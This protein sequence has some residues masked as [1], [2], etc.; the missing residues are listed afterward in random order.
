MSTQTSPPKNSDGRPRRAGDLPAPRYRRLFGIQK[1]T[2]IQ[3]GIFVV[4]VVLVLAPLVPTIYQ[5]LLNKPLYAAGGIFTPSNYVHLFTEGGFGKVVLNSLYFAALTTVIAVAISIILAVLVIRTK[6]PAGRAMGGLLLWPIYISPL[7]MAFGFILMYG[8]SGFISTAARAVI[9][10]VPWNL[11]SIPG[12]AF[13]QAVT[14]VPI[15]YLYCSGALKL[16]D[17][18]L[19]AAARTCGAKPLRILW[20]VVIP[21]VRPAIL[22]SALLIFS[23]SIEELSIPLLLGRPS[24]INMFSSFIYINGLAKS[25]PDYGLVGAASVVT[26][27]VMAILITIQAISLRNARRF[28][29]VGGKAARPRLLDLGGIRWVGFAFAVL[30]LIFG[31]LLPIIGLVLRAFTQLLTP[32]VNPL[33]LLTLD[34]FTLIFDYPAYVDSIKNSLIVAVVGAIVTTLFVSV[35]VLVAR[36][37][38]FRF[39]RILEFTA[40]S[41]QVMPGL[42]LGI[43]FFWAFALIKPLHGVNGTLLA[44]IIAFGVRSLPAAFGAVAPMVMQIGEELDNAARTLGADWWRTFSRIL[45]KLVMPAMFAALVLLFIQMFKE[46]TP[47]IFLANSNSQVIG[48]TTLQLWLNGNSGSVAALSCIQIAITTVFVLVAGKVFKVRSYA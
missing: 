31:P 43:G 13:A 46:F 11:Y 27:A 30:Y 20:S 47:A 6:M 39:R 19:E 38:L 24:G 10:T 3:Y 2:W 26:L 36:R 37:S 35:I 34:N 12:M 4:A 28:V 7:V 40:L 22:Y 45:F 44:L 16:S 32:L 42:I 48:T 23:T 1:A 14:L 18:S 15:G 17:P 25:N 29:A 21:M 5:S 8:P 9:G 33:S 41:P